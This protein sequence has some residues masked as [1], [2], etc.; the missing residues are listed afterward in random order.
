MFKRFLV[1]TL[2]F[3]SLGAGCTS[4]D[5]ALILEQ[6]RQIDNLTL[7]LVSTTEKVNTM[8]EQKSK[9]PGNVV[10]EKVNLKKNNVPV[11]TF[12]KKSTIIK[13]EK[14]TDDDVPALDPNSAY[15]DRLNED[16]RKTC[17]MNLVRDEGT[18]WTKDQVST[19][20]VLIKKCEVGLEIKD[21]TE[22]TGKTPFQALYESTQ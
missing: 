12:I 13:Q 21:F 9:Q 22:K 11:D 16:L 8:E 17:N 6:Q 2:I 19:L 7:Q 18:L 14:I 20:Y 4:S 3:I 5:G 10:S 15:Y 1:V